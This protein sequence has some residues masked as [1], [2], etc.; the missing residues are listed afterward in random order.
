MGS[1][2]RF[3]IPLSN[4]ILLREGCCASAVLRR[5]LR[6]LGRIIVLAVVTDTCVFCGSEDEET[7]LICV[8]DNVI[9]KV[10]PDDERY[11]FTV[12]GMPFLK[13]E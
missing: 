10:V 1:F 3:H 4:K 2:G 9:E 8:M 5:S 12:L 6:A 13:V 11:D 7:Y